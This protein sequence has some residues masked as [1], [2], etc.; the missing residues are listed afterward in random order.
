MTSQKSQTWIFNPCSF[1]QVEEAILHTMRPCTV[2]GRWKA[3]FV[4]FWS[5]ITP[6][7]CFNCQVLRCASYLVKRSNSRRRR[8]SVSKIRPILH[9]DTHP[10]CHD[11]SYCLIMRQPVETHRI[12]EAA[13]NVPELSSLFHHNRAAAMKLLFTVPWCDRNLVRRCRRSLFAGSQPEHMT[14]FLENLPRSAVVSRSCVGL[15]RREKSACCQRKS[16]ETASTRTVRH[17]LLWDSSSQPFSCSRVYSGRLVLGK[18]NSGCFPFLFLFIFCLSVCQSTSLWPRVVF[19][20]NMQGT[21]GM[22]P[23]DE[24]WHPEPY[25]ICAA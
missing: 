21:D 10:R 18:R 24:S 12:G 2:D 1:W 15:W 23:L 8:R 25:C 20:S 7:N 3:S 14:L 4:M 9:Q 6:V 5:K 16:D 11:E 17:F 22:P 13:V 19:V